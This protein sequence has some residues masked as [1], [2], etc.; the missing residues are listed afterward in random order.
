MDAH[1]E[2][3]ISPV[4]L[5][6]SYADEDEELRKELEK[7]LSLLQQQGVIAGWHHHK[8]MPG[9]NRGQASDEHISSAQIILLLM[10]PDFLASN[11]SHSQMQRALQ[12]HENGL[13]HVIPLLLCP[14]D[15]E[16]A[17]FA[18]L[19][20]LP[21]NGQPV[22]T[23]KNS[24]LAFVDIAEGLRSA[25]EQW[26]PL[27]SRDEDRFLQASI[28]EPQRIQHKER[29]QRKRYTRRM[30]LI[31]LAGV[32]GMIGTA[33]LAYPL[34]GDTS[35]PS[36]SLPYTYTGHTSNV[37]SVTWSP[38][39]ERIAS[40]SFDNTVQ[41]WDANSGSL[42][43]TYKGHT[44]SIWSVAWSPD[45]KCIASGSYDKT[46]QVWDASSG[47]FLLTYKGHPDPVRSVAWSPDG[48]HIASGSDDSTVQVW[49]A[50]SNSLLLTYKGHTD[51]VSSVAASPDG[52]HIA[53]GSLDKTVQVWDAS[54]GS[55]L[56]TYK[57][58]TDYIL[59]VAWSPDGKHIA[60]GSLDNTVQVWGV[61]S[62]R[63]LK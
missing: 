58:H 45:G 60:F 31:G 11:A 32:M 28:E 35:P 53:S 5:F 38:D 62:T 49:D 8:V 17:L 6:Y 59:S 55:L 15:W 37:Y 52:K 39:G 29:Q 44:D 20:V 54:S 34:H 22:T 7:H 27:P 61:F 42:L 10:S 12:R 21:R 3:S 26:Y 56:L 24:D 43:L 36:K 41:V 23:W 13:A 14:V 47:S 1:P 40:G 18:H 9:A 48:K 19:H 2:Q 33:S 16:P 63:K 30:V 50:S 4:T 46:V 57:G 25:I 51:S